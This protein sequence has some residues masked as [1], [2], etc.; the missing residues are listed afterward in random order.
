MSE[1]QSKAPILEAIQRFHE[2]NTLPFTTPGHKVGQGID[3]YTASILGRSAFVNDITELAGLNDRHMSPDVTSQAEQLAAEVYGADT[4]MFSTNGSSLSAHVVMLT[5]A[6]KGDTVI[7]ARNMHR[8]VMAAIILS[9]IEPVWLFPPVD[10]DIQVHHG[11]TAEQVRAML[12][13]YPHAKAVVITSP[14]YYGVAADVK[15]I[16]DACHEHDL[17]LFVDAAWGPHFH[18]HPELP[19][20][21]IESGADISVGSIHKVQGGLSQAS[22]INV[23]GP[24]IDTTL[25]KHAFYLFETTSMS[26]L[27]TGSIDG[28]RRNMA[29][30]GEEIWGRTLNLARRVRQAVAAIPGLR[31]IGSEVLQRPGAAGLDE[32]KLVIDVAGLGMTGMQAADWLDQHCHITFELADQRLMMGLITPGDTEESVDRLIL[33]LQELGRW[34]QQHPQQKQQ[35]ALPTL[36]EIQPE[37][38]AH[39]RDCLFGPTRMVPLAE[40]AGEIAA[41][42]ISPYPPGIPTIA[43]GERFTPPIVAFLQGMMQMDT[44]VPDSSDSSLEQVRVVA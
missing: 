28:D 31:M 41:E 44:A 42:I 20:P 13:A 36:R 27:I 16:A 19:P 7:F 26:S 37:L 18:F 43:P 23:K 21:A 39:P 1:D 29:L 11:P 10:P 9:E 32:T 35:V 40:A 24:R 17:P 8:S 6:N 30:H 38:V 3:E 5:L 33:A 2:K 34:A 15:G 14:D 12:A 4:T 25:L 22:I